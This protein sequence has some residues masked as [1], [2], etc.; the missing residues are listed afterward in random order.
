M[1]FKIQAAI[2]LGFAITLCACSG[3]G[4][5]GGSGGSSGTSTQS[6]G[7]SGSTTGN[8]TVRVTDAPFPV[9]F[10]DNAFVEI[11]SVEVRDSQ[12]GGGFINVS[13]T[14]SRVDLIPLTGGVSE[15][16]VDVNIPPGTY[17]EVRL[18]VGSGEVVL[19]SSAFVVGNT[20]VF[21]TAN[22]NLSFP[23]GPQ[24]GIKVRIDPPI[25][26]STQL[27]A[28]LTLDFALDRNFVFNG[29]FDRN[30]GVR[31]VL[32]TPVVRAVNTSTN[33]RFIIDVL[34]DNATP[35][36]LSDDFALAG[37]T[38][39]ATDSTGATASTFT[40]ANGH[41]ELPLAPG[42]YDV[43]VDFQGH[44]T[45][46]ITQQ[47]IVLANATSLGTRI[48]TATSGEIF[49]LV[50]SDATTPNDSNDDQVLSG[51]TVELLQ[52]GSVVATEV[53]DSQG[54]YRFGSLTPGLYDLR[55]NQ[56]GFVAANQNNVSTS[57]GNGNPTDF[58]LEALSQRVS[59]V[60]T[61]NQGNPVPSADISITR[62]DGFGMVFTPSLQ[63]T[64]N[65]S[66]SVQLGTG[67]YSCEFTD[68]TSGATTSITLNV[69]GT[70]P[71]S[72]LTGQDAQLP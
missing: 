23:S 43:T 18:F 51:V 5:S 52:N 2:A 68:A 28:D 19:N 30:P 12:A 33:G 17:D 67:S 36:N 14:S 45:L 27:S 60:L 13:S 40:D 15:K 37:A 31:R 3:G 21:N 65:G 22:N 26:V 32:F 46:S 9:N 70:D 34:G 63:T 4:S 44:D 54:S 20:R 50:N 61:D 7:T 6:S 56:A 59:G 71:T 69:V 72:D 42:T 29:R 10:V 25:V 38:V 35:S 53:T 64:G 62:S 55:V 11:T 39:T 16:I 66:Y 48:L 41:A 57:S 47:S 49:G 8:L 58:L 24:T 1:K